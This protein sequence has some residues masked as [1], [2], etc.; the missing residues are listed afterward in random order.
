MRL[1]HIP[2][3]LRRMLVLSAGHR[4]YTVVVA[5]LAFVSTVT[6]TFPFAIVLIS[7]VLI[8]PRRWLTLG[9]ACG[10]ASG[11]GAAVLVELSSYIGQELFLSH[12]AH[13]VRSDRWQLGSEWIRKYGLFALAVIAGSPVPQTPALLFYSLVNPSV[14]GVLVA[15]GIGKTVKYV[16][17]AWATYRFPARFLRYP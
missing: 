14:P 16:F 4:Y 2:D 8:A 10:L 13:L 3:P 1:P 15:V 17:L 9:L 7:S 11:L 12:F 5:T 6:F